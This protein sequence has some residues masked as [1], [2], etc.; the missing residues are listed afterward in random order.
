ML[1]QFTYPALAV[2]Q[3]KQIRLMA[4]CPVL[5]RTP[6]CQ[7]QPFLSV[8][9]SFVHIVQPRK[10]TFAGQLFDAACKQARLQSSITLDLQLQPKFLLGRAGKR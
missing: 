3:V 9:N 2:R 5:L 4:V 6:P 7:Q 10:I 1:D 8:L